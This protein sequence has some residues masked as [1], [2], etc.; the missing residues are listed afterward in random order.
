MPSDGAVKLVTWRLWWLFWCD[1]CHQAELA[2]AGLPLS[3]CFKLQ[4]PLV[5][6]CQQPSGLP[7]RQV[8]DSLALSANKIN[9]RGASQ[10]KPRNRRRRRRKKKQGSLV[11]NTSPAPG[12]L[13]IRCATTPIDAHQSGSPRQSR[14]PIALYQLQFLLF[15]L[16][17]LMP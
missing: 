9:V 4:Q 10:K 8:V 13:T 2:S 12:V 17:Y 5:Y 16:S 1:W 3:V 15:H 6:Q 7:G 14:S 11:T